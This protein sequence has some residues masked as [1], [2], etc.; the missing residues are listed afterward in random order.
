MQIKD[1]KTNR[2]SVHVLTNYTRS[3]TY[4]LWKEHG[5]GMKLLERRKHTC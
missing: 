2:A 3:D 5:K 4:K 1:P